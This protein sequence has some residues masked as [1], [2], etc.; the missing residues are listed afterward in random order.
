MQ[1]RRAIRAEALSP[2]PEQACVEI[3]GTGAEERMPP[4]PPESTAGCEGDV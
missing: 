4:L 2:V 3:H 1:T